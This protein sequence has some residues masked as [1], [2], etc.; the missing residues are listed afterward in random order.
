MNGVVSTH[1]L[2]L[3]TEIR[4]LQND[5][6]FQSDMAKVLLKQHTNPWILASIELG[7]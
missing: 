6:L 7:L 2:R 4:H 5:K 1:W 3:K